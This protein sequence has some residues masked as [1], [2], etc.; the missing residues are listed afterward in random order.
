VIIP[1]ERRRNILSP[2]DEF[3][4][5][6]RTM[7]DTLDGSL[8]PLTNVEEM[9]E[10]IKITMDLP[11]V[12][13]RDIKIRVSDVTLDIEAKLSRVITF[14]K[15]GTTQKQC[16]FRLFRKILNLPAHV[17]TTG[18]K[19]TFKKGLLVVELPKVT[20]ENEVMIE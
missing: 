6:F 3:E 20:S 16:E 7:W 2:F 9:D 8:E 1:R 4:D 17:T 14:K 13:K 19:A 15:W 11:L 5:T 18:A 12:W 10:I